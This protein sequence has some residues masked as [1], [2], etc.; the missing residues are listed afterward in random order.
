MKNKNVKLIIISLLALSL[1][2]CMNNE[3]KVERVS[4]IPS[5]I[6]KLVLLKDGNHLGKMIRKS[7]VRQGFIVPPLST[8]RGITLKSKDKDIHFSQSEARYGISV[9][10]VLS[11]NNPC[12]TN[13]NAAD[14]TSLEY[15]LIDLKTNKTL[16]FVSKGGR[17]DT[18]P[19]TGDVFTSTTTLLD[20]LAKE[21]AQEIQ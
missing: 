11:S 10:G 15:E 17:T 12:W 14:F 7:L 1:I 13:S 20:D 16:L 2:G 6:E 18:C 5:G 21:L 9:D 3:L 8:T 4:K 19:G